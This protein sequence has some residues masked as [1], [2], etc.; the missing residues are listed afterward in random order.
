MSG[1]TKKSKLRKKA[2]SP[3]VKK[4]NTLRAIGRR[5]AA[6]EGKKPFFFSGKRKSKKRIPKVLE[7]IIF[8]TGESGMKKKR[9]SRRK[10]V[11]LYRG[12]EF[13]GRRVKRH[14]KKRHSYMG[15]G[16]DKKGM[17]GQM[18]DGVSV[19]GGVLA[20]SFVGKM[21]PV[22]NPKIQA[23]VPVAVGI[24]LSMTKIGKQGIGK[25]ISLGMVSVGMLSLIR[26]LVPS[27]PLMSG[28]EMSLPL[29][30]E[31]ERALLGLTTEGD[32]YQDSG[33]SGEIMDMSGENFVSAENV[34]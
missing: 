11:G 1:K 22:K 4:L 13:F 3:L 9:V 16:F 27:L 33:V 5:S 14:H 31:E 7:P 10:K 2:K 32:T 12:G 34:E 24:G 21:V 30:A 19:V 20:G 23:L 25:Y 17:T 18:I 29:N 15:L 28:D 8:K 6:S 26:Q